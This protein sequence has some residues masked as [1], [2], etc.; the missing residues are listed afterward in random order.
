MERYFAMKEKSK[1]TI[2]KDGWLHTGDIGAWFENGT[3]W[4][5]DRANNIFKTSLGE[6]V[7]PDKIERALCTSYVDPLWWYL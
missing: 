1:S 4:I 2:G 7:Q 6:Y 5:I 3:L